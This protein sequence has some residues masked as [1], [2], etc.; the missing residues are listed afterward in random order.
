MKKN[1]IL[2]VAVMLILGGMNPGVALI[3]ATA[4]GL[5]AGLVTGILN[6]LL[7]IPEKYSVEAILSLGIPDAD[8]GEKELPDPDS[9]KVHYGRF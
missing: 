5:L 7:G 4:A 3:F 9:P 2:T 8:P 6:T 1:D